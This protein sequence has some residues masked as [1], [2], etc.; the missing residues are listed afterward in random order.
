MYVKYKNSVRHL[1]ITK[2]Y[3]S[4]KRANDWIKQQDAYLR[5]MVSSGI[6]VGQTAKTISEMKID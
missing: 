3:W 2:Y 1:L 5:G 6:P 4:T